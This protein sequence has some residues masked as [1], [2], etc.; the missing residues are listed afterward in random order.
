MEVFRGQ[1]RNGDVQSVKHDWPL[2][3]GHAAAAVS[4]AIIN[5]TQTNVVQIS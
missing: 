5:Q 3:N 1:S 2:L 4:I